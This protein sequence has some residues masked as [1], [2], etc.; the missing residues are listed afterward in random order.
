MEFLMAEASSIRH[1][2]L[3]EKYHVSLNK[4]LLHDISDPDFYGEL[5]Y[6]FKKISKK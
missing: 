4:L 2:E 3:I 6:K 5:V 1:F